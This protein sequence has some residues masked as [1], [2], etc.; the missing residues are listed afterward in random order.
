LAG[1][2]DAEGAVALGS[3]IAVTHLTVSTVSMLPPNLVLLPSNPEFLDSI[4]TSIISCDLV[5]SFRGVA[6][7]ITHVSYFLFASQQAFSI[8]TRCD[9]SAPEKSHSLYAT[10]DDP[11][12]ALRV[13]DH[14]RTTACFLR[15]STLSRLAASKR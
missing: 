1:A 10:T 7:A 5:I 11:F 12:F 4:S 9:N 14:Q 8:A 3:Q 15:L 6:E 13:S 2:E